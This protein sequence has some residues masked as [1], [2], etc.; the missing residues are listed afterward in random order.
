MRQQQ[1]G[2][3]HPVLAGTGKDGSVIFTLRL[4][5][6]RGATMTANLERAPAVWLHWALPS[7]ADLFFLILIGIL[8]FSPMSAG[9]LRDADT[10]WHIRNGEQIL[11]THA[12]PRSDPFS[13]TK[14]GE[15]WYAWEWM[16]DVVIAAIHHVSGLNGVVLFTAVVI[17]VTFA[18]LFRFILQRSGNL[19]VAAFLTLLATA[20]SQ[21]HMLA[22]PHVL[23][24]LLTLL[25]VENLCRFEDGERSALL[26]LPLLMLLWVNLHAGFILGLGLLGIF[27]M[28]RIWSSLTV[29]RDGD[30]RRIAQLVIAFSV[31]LLTTLLT[32]YGYRLHIHVYQ[33]LSN[34]FLMDNIDEFSS[35]N[36]HVPVYGYFE[37]FIPLVIGGAVLGRD[38]LTPT[39]FLLL[40][41]SLHAGLYAAR[42][43]PISAIIM[44]LVLGPLMTVAISP[45]S[46]CSSRPRWLRFL[47]DTGQGVSDSMTRLESQLQGHVLVAVV[48]A[49]SVA[50]VLNG[51]RVFSKQMLAAHFD[52]RAFP[53][54]AAQF[55]AQRGIRDHLFSS[56][57]WGAYLI[58]SLYPGTKVYFDDRHD[59]YGEAFV[60]D[61]GKAISGSRQWR[62]LLDRYQVRWVLMPVDSPLSSLLRESPDWRADYDD[63]L[64]IIFS[65]PEACGQRGETPPCW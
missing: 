28:G 46:G 21:V 34:S 44:S 25:W 40:L 15:P 9:L 12:I 54:K 55:I 7:F 19:G 62:E 45:R 41:F 60:K 61:Y 35:P 37:L 43:I 4:S 11:A 63:G 8:A 5:R 6:L 36:F 29:P 56:D 30:R 57:T 51:G 32:P 49:A 26:W 50:L 14:H 27:T 48:M 39:G 65:R 1:R 24:W 58:Y 33:Y 47:L 2:E 52:E 17:S 18:L 53:V 16:Y 23:S 38:R 22:R 59:F 10:G 3:I 13:Y 42:N 20:A 64:A 31:C